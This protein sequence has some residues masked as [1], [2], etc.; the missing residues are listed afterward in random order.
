MLFT[1]ILYLLRRSGYFAHFSTRMI[2]VFYLLN[3]AACGIERGGIRFILTRMRK[4]GFN[5]KD[6]DK[7][8]FGN[9]RKFFRF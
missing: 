1:S 2:A 3:I 4:Q 8:A 6:I 9:A 5:Q 7:I